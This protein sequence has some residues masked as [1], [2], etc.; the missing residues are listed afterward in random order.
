MD[1]LNRL[2]R[3][4][5][6]RVLVGLVLA[7]FFLTPP[8]LAFA[9]PVTSVVG[10]PDGWARKDVTFWLSIDTSFRTFT[11]SLQTF[12]GFDMEPWVLYG[13]PLTAKGTYTLLTTPM[14]VSGEGSRLLRCFSKDNQGDQ[15]P[16]QR[17]ADIYTWIRIDKSLPSSTISGLPSGWTGP[18]VYSFSIAA[19]DAYSGVAST[20]YSIDGGAPVAYAGPTPVTVAATTR[21]EYWSVDAAGNTEAA[22]TAAVKVDLTGEPVTVISGVPRSWS[23]SDV[24]FSLLAES[25]GGR[26][27]ATYFHLGSGGDTTYSG[28]TRIDAEGI[29]TVAYHSVNDVGPIEPERT[30]VIR[31]DRT[32]PVS[33]A[34][35]IPSGWTTSPVTFS[36]GATDTGSGVAS[37]W[38]SLDG[39]R[40]QAYTQ[41]VTVYSNGATELSWWAVDVADNAEPA[42][43]ATIRI[44]REG[45]VTSVSGVPD[46]WGRS[47]VTFALSAV[48]AHYS[49][50]DTYYRVGVG[51]FIR[52]S[53]P[54]TVSSDGLTTV[55]YYSVDDLGMQEPMRSI[56]VKI[57]KAPPV[58]TVSGI[59]SGPSATDVT[60]RLEAVDAVTPVS[61]IRYRLGGGDPVSYGGPVTVS[62]EGV[63]ALSWWA[64]DAAGNVEP[65]HTTSID[66]RRVSGGPTP[67]PT[68]APTPEPTPGPIA[69]PTPTPTQPPT[70]SPTP[71]ASPT[72]TPVP[73]PTPS[74]SPVPI[75]T[76][77]PLTTSDATSTY[78]GSA[79]VQL[80]ALD[81]VGG[82]GVEKTCYRLD[83]GAVIT[84][85]TASVSGSG[86]HSLEFW[87]VDV[88]GNIELSHTVRFTIV[89]PTPSLATI[90][91]PSAPSSVRRGRAFTA[92]GYLRPKHAAG[93]FAV[94]IQCYLLVSGVWKSRKTVAVKV[95]GYKTYSKYS[96]PVS[97][98][99]RGRWRIRA[100]H[101][102]SVHARSY[103]RYRY[104]TV[105]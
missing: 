82:S 105:K 97:L 4:R 38:F 60:F 61:D 53:G 8:T 41:P 12:Y 64:V 19:A 100:F 21:I 59:P 28:P 101:S 62:A 92:F 99:S 71:I 104:V 85:R 81:E 70:P 44:D 76:L 26:P 78:A 2:P 23:T 58:S 55:Q 46:G 5:R 79:V 51:P 6:F 87:S 96:G 57:D 48:S 94:R 50:A 43:S 22:K 25:P 45:P 49:V 31:I 16:A 37:V 68:P 36:L 7:A 102:D 56:E 9:P 29:T 83:G 84:G 1:R 34:Y 20:H 93:T 35:G 63:T 103:S 27:T 30:A 17:E 11:T 72:A 86:S 39:D 95:A 90:T 98:P 89:P 32:S 91:T 54:V 52:Y 24:I 47:D 13:G 74:P 14:T 10:V 73:S 75:D 33:A 69:S 66:I 42:H 80:I 40:P 88:A 15:V 77:A 65:A 18:G 67:T 3:I